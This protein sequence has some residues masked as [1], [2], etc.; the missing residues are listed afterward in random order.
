[1]GGSLNAKQS[2]F[3]D[4]YLIDLNAT[5][6]AKRAGYSE[7]TAEVIGAQ[8]LKKTLVKHAVEQAIALR[9]ARTGITQERILEELRRI[10]FSDKRRLTSWGADGV[11]LRDCDELADEDAAAVSE[12]SETVTQHGGSLRIK[13]HDKVKALELLGRHIGMFGDPSDKPGDDAEMPTRIEIEF[14]DASVPRD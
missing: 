4:E 9:S 2:R 13:T 12:I 10:A 1:M 3:V 5:Q 7:K 8:L 14:V 6:A 11:R